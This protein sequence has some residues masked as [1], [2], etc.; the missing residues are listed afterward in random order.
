MKRT[1]PIL[2][3][4]HLGEILSRVRRRAGLT[5]KELAERTGINAS[6]ISKYESGKILL[7]DRNLERI[8]DA[9]GYSSEQ[10]IQDARALSRE[11]NPPRPAVEPDPASAFP[12][13]ELERIYDE[14]AMEGKSLYLRTC[15]ALFDA[16]WKASRPR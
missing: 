4:K 8:C 5:Q 15:R 2:E 1:V 11:G 13:A 3:K 16:L 10:L 9:T 14:S 7:G 12:R 6:L